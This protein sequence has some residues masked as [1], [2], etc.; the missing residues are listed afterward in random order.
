MARDDE[1]PYRQTSIVGP[2]DVQIISS[3]TRAI[4]V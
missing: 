4:V 3:V 2:Q 1:P